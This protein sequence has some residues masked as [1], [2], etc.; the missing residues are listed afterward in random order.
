VVSSV[1]SFGILAHPSLP[2]PA[3]TWTQVGSFALASMVL[4]M[5]PG[6]S[7]LF[8]IARGIALGR[9]AALATVL[10]N[11][12]GIGVHVVAVSVGVGAIVARSVTVFTAMK[13]A[14][15]AYLVFL[16]IRAIRDRRHLADALAATV[17]P[18]SDRRLL[19]DGFVVGVSNPKTTL[20]FLAVLP[21]FVRPEAGH[22]SLQLLALGLL[23]CV[24]AVLNDSTYGIAAGSVGRWLKRSPRRAEAIGATSGVLLVGLG[25]RLA[26]TGRKD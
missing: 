14:G 6:P 7:V 15:A 1:I 8:V 22:P 2:C 3:V 10:G 23:F 26:L 16:G 18:K 17:V 11:T 13:L 5:L 20:F 21:Q 19:R 25:V 4:L 9:R 12:M 24:L